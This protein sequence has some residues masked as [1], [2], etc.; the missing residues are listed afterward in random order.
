[1]ISRDLPLE[2]VH[3]VRNRVNVIL[4]VRFSL[5]LNKDIPQETLVWT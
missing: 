3:F 2:Y 1:M 4:T 5:Q